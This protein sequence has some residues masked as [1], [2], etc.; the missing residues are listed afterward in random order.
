MIGTVIAL[1]LFVTII[2]IPVGVLVMFV[3]YKPLVSYY[4]KSIQEE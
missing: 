2:L 1:A 3:T 4:K